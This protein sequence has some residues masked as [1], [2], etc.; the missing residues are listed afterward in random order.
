MLA[1]GAPCRAASLPFAVRRLGREG[2]GSPNNRYRHRAYRYRYMES[3]SRRLSWE[4]KLKHDSVQAAL[5]TA[6]AHVAHGPRG[7]SLKYMN[8]S[9]IHSWSDELSGARP[10]RNIEDVEREAVDHLLDANKSGRKRQAEHWAP[11]DNI[12]KYLHAKRT[13]DCA[14]PETDLNATTLAEEPKSTKSFNSQEKG[15]Q[16]PSDL[17]KYNPKKFD[18]PIAPRPLT[19]EE[20]SKN[21][22]DLDKYKPVE[23]NEP[24]GLP[25][26][27][28][29]QRSKQYKDLDKYASPDV[30]ASNI[31]ADAAASTNPKYDDLDKYKPTEWN[32]PD[33][34]RKQT[35]EESSKSYDDLHKYGPAT[36]NEPDGMPKQTPEESSKNYGDLGKYGPVA[37]NE[38]DGLP[39]LTA[40]EKS[41]Q[42][43]DLDAYKKPFVA[44]DSILEAHEAKQQD[45]TARADPVAAKVEVPAENPATEYDDLNKYTPVTWNE[46]DGLPKPT[47][48]ELSKNYDDLPTYDQ[49]PNN[50]PATPRLHPEEA[51][52]QYGDLRRYGSFPN[53]GPVTERVHPEDVSKQYKDVSKYP[54]RGFDEPKR[55][56]HVHPEELSKNYKDL[57][58]YDPLS[59]D[60]PD[61]SHPAY[62][63]E[64]TKAYKDL[65][66]YEPVFHTKLDAEPAERSGSVP[67]SLQD[68][69]NYRQL[70]GNEPRTA[71]EIRSAVLRR[72]RCNSTHADAA[73]Q[74][75]DLADC[76]THNTGR[77]LTGSYA[78]DFPEE[79]ATSWNTANSWSKSTLFPKH[80]ADNDTTRPANTLGS[81]KDE[82]DLSSMDES[83]PSEDDRLQPA[84]ERNAGRRASVSGMSRS[85]RISVE[86]D[87]YPSNLQRLEGSYAKERGGLATRPNLVR[88]DKGRSRDKDASGT[89]ST[90]QG[91]FERQP[92]LYKMLAYDPSTQSISVA[93][94]SSAADDS[95][96][97][98]TPAE[99]LPRISNPSKFFPY[100]RVLQAEGYEV[101]SGSGHVLVFR[102]VQP[103]S[104][105]QEDSGAAVE[106]TATTGRSGARKVAGPVHS[107]VNDESRP[108]LAPGWEAWDKKTKRRRLGR[109]LV[110]GTA[111]VAGIAYAGSLMGEYLSTGGK[112]F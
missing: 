110:I 15:A 36:W 106:S 76:K 49:Y 74:T 104:V 19:S 17:Q 71:A 55:S 20:S 100:F 99:I 97:A 64:A 7:T 45:F 25:T 103:G 2:Q 46:P 72:A 85:E 9:K 59:F 107:F 40:E 91:P 92:T 75:K 82:F 96:A 102:K 14:A 32:E 50:G 37:W 21:Y 52:K 95:S 80:L 26:Q 31:S 24:D 88:G 44:A 70:D 48:E 112:S 81:D 22:H 101:V 28:P 18:S 57:D 53:A 69:E 47:P 109:K 63:E 108:Y 89:D 10:G 94:A 34:L 38:P 4:N 27:T 61:N 62:S 12:R 66:S 33:G 58:K 105:L 65:A 11:F 23:W 41:K 90:A 98:E 87:P 29:E 42:Y 78:K 77:A 43:D 3:L 67:N 54:S 6:F 84:L 86:E 16:K 60:Q 13:P 56:T 73:G 5:K 79:F 111:W 30:D 51:S 8:M 93:E 39:Q 1:A 35:P 68:Y 83:F